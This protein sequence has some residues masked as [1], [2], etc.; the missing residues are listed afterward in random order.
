MIK[1]SWAQSLSGTIFLFCSFPSMLEGF[2]QNL[3]QID[4]LQKTPNVLTCSIPAIVHNDYILNQHSRR[5]SR[6]ELFISNMVATN[7]VHDNIERW[8]SEHSSVHITIPAS[9]LWSTQHF[10]GSNY[11][12]LVKSINIWWLWHFMITL[13]IWLIWKPTFVVVSSHKC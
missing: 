11:L 9:Y 2:C 12:W 3:A 6:V 1:R 4:E 13:L 7:Y 8:L 5:D 10:T